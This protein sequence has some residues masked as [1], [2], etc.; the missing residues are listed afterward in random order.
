MNDDLQHLKLLSIFH[1]VVAGFTA[2]TGCFPVFHLAIGVALLTGH[3]PNQAA[4]PA[5][6]D[7]MGW[8]FAGIAG[9]I[10][11]VMWSLA[12]L[13]LCTGRFLQAH[14]RH[15]FCLVVAG[16]ECLLMPFGTILGVFTIIVLLRPSVR[17][18][19]DAADGTGAASF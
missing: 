6:T 15:T 11:A 13:L 12:V 7:L 10:I 14:R 1:Y 3:M 5:A 16:L 9:A 17:Q 4:D 2:L 8:M 19:F 18:L